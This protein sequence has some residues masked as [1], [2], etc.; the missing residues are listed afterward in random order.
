MF[1]TTEEYIREMHASFKKAE[2]SMFVSL[3]YTRTVDV[4][5]NLVDRFVET[6]SYGIEGLT[7]EL[8]NKNEILVVPDTL[9]EKIGILREKFKEDEKIM[10][11]LDFIL[12]LRKVSRSEHGKCEEFRKNVTMV[13]VVE[14]EEHNINIPVLQE[15]LEKTKSY[16]KIFEELALGKKEED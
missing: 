13:A 15:Y 5:K 12:F 8:E 6:I 14:G 16:L 7:L 2:H 4:I 9:I 1:N 3:K 11:C 10:E